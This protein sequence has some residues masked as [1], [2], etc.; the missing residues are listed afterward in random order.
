MQTMEGKHHETDLHLQHWL[1]THFSH[2]TSTHV[3]PVPIHEILEMNG[4]P[5]ELP[6]ATWGPTSP[7]LS[8][9]LTPWL[10]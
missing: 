5:D 2:L 3:T 10:R 6:E 8:L 9:R 4:G 7:L 1:A